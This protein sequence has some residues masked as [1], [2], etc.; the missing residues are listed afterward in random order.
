MGLNSTRQ[1]TARKHRIFLVEDHPILREGFAQL[2]TR[3]P[4]FEVCGKADEV[5]DGF[6]Q[7]L[8][9]KPDLV[10]VDI[11]LK[12]S[13]GLELITRLK[14]LQVP[15]CVLALSMHEEGLYAARALQAGANGYVMK[16]TPIE[17]V[18]TAIRQVLKGEQYLSQ[19]MQD[20]MLKP[21]SD[22]RRDRIESGLKRLTKRELQVFQMIGRGARTK[23]IATEL[24][25]SVKTVESY[26][27]HLIEKLCLEDGTELVH[28]AVQVLNE[29]A[30]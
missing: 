10:I 18:M 19:K 15:R 20:R 24:K 6:K 8:A 14:A 23:E 7:I 3:Q 25:L 9:C 13:S 1:T 28:H 22:A 4:D 30:G 26:R 11:E 27:A 2:L 29:S 12:Q 21:T 16:Q 17:E 5:E